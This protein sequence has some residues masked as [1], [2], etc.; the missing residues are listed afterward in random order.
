M[1]YEAGNKMLYYQMTESKYTRRT[2]TQKKCCIQPWSN[3]LGEI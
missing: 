2:E 1:K 3:K